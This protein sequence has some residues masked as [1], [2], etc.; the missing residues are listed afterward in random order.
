MDIRK[1]FFWSSSD[2][3][4]AWVTLLFVFAGCS[5]ESAKNS[6]AT[7][8]TIAQ[9]ICDF[10]QDEA[11]MK[12]AGWVK[13]FEDNFESDLSQWNVW[14]GGAY[15]EE[16]QHYQASNLEVSEGTLLIKAKKETV[17]G[18]TTPQ[19]PIQKSFDF[20]SGR[21]ECKTNISANSNAPRVRIAAR[22]KLPVGKGLWPAFWSYGDPWPTQGEI[23]FLEARGNEPSK[24]QTNYFFGTSTNNNLVKGAE[25][26]IETDANLTTC[27][28]VYELIWEESKLTSILDGTIVEVKTSGGYIQ[29]LFGKQQRVTL[30]VAVGGWFFNNLDPSTIEEGTMMVDW[31]RVYTSN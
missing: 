27:Y 16:L 7:I 30:N 4:V 22:I 12:S 24:Y 15:N 5:K 3:N 2:L 18:N 21:I 10:E 11:G 28:H 25:H 9:T 20:T 14:T 26:V 8:P 6:D 31:V 29:Q 23:D 1:L 17:S 13:V 19:E